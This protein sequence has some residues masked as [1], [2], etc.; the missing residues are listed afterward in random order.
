MF[1]LSTKA[2]E[3][4]FISRPYK[5]EIRLCDC[6]SQECKGRFLTKVGSS[7]TVCLFELRRL[8]F[9]NKIAPVMEIIE[10]RITL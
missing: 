7:Q 8:E 9:K 10:E 3:M 2:Y 4:L 1:T 6:Y 5:T